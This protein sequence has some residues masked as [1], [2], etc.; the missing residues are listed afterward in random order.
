MCVCCNML[1]CQLQGVFC[2]YTIFS[3]LESSER[4][5]SMAFSS[6][7]TGTTNK[8]TW[9]KYCRQDLAKECQQG[10]V[11]MTGSC[12][13]V[14]LMNM[15][16]CINRNRGNITLLC[17]QGLP[18]ADKVSSEVQQMW[19]LTEMLQANQPATRIGRFDVSFM[20]LLFLFLTSLLCSQNPST[21]RIVKTFVPLIC[22]NL[23]VVDAHICGLP[24]WHEKR[25]V[26]SG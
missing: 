3:L 20:L 5:S 4:I 7:T 8:P 17:F 24:S 12:W 14:A 11:R 19:V 10:L 18:D 13:G 16:R 25:P 1:A 2:S 15:W 21:A 9:C 6:I 26:E 23:Q 22:R